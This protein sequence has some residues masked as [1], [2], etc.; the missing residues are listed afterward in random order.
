MYR[1]AENHLLILL[2]SL[3]FLLVFIKNR[4]ENTGNLEMGLLLLTQLDAEQGGYWYIE[5]FYKLS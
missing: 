2:R 3:I 5:F 4:K 1:Q